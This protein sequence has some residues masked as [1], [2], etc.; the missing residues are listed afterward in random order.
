MSARILRGTLAALALLCG[1]ALVSCGGGDGAGGAATDGPVRDTLVIAAPSDAA[2]LLDV[3]SQSAS[4]SA[5]IS[6]IFYPMIDSEFDC[7]LKA[8]PALAKEWSWNEDGTVL[9]MTLRDDITWQD[10]KKVTAEDVAFAMSLVEDPQVASPRISYIKTMIEGA[11]P[12]H[13]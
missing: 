5:I 12:G 9:S 10:G 13:R 2:N 11:R 8:K 7:E 4:D 1:P 6:N 3:V